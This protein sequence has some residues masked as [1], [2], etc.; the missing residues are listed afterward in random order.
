MTVIGYH[1]SHEQLPPPDLLASVRLAESVGFDAAMC[2]DH[3]APWTRAQGQSGF[4]W[5]WLGAALAST[6]FPLGVVA[7]PGQRYHPVILAQAIATVEQMFP[8]RFWAALGSGEAIN[9]HVTGTGWPEKAYR[10]RRLRECVDVIRRLLDGE[11][12]TM[13]STILVDD[14]RIWSRPET[15]PP[16]FG[17]AVSAKTAGWVAEWADGLITVGFDPSA[18]GAALS[19]FREA[20][21]SGDA[22]LQI[23]VSLADTEKEALHVAREQWSHAAA[24]A[25]LMWDV[26]QPEEFEALADPTE[27]KLNES[28]IITASAEVMASRIASAAQGFDQVYIHH[29]GV[30]QGPFLRRCQE[31]LL[32]A[33]RRVM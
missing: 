33:L 13:D 11:R 8:G 15:P 19:A 30:D 4:A 1:A 3:L 31:Q 28:V 2:S 25:E 23:H 6:R 12:V 21:G 24:P 29:V 32:P 17:A 10:E 22:V 9:E 18:T 16:L 27:E 14:A 20:G 5:A 7:A 26:D